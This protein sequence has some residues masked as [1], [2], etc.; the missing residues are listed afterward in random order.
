[1]KPSGPH[2]RTKLVRL[3]IRAVGLSIW[4]GTVTSGSTLDSALA[5]G[6]CAMVT[7]TGNALIPTPSAL[8]SDEL[9]LASLLVNGLNAGDVDAVVSLFGPEAIIEADRFAW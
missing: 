8:R 5:A 1:M 2:L 6:A 9:A 3:A 4:L 7:S